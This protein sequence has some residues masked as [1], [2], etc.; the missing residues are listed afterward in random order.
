MKYKQSSFIKNKQNHFQQ[1]NDNDNNGS[2]GNSNNNNNNNN[3]NGNNGTR[4]YTNNNY[5]TNGNHEADHH[6]HYHNH[7][8]RQY[9]N[10]NDL[11]VFQDNQEQIIDKQQDLQITPNTNPT[12][13]LTPSR[14]DSYNRINSTSSST[15][16]SSTNNTTNIVKTPSSIFEFSNIINEQKQQQLKPS[17]P[18]IIC[19]KVKR[20]LH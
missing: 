4:N 2:N 14:K 13:R 16:S 10:N 3:N 19:S 18:I 12:N 11:S 9:D 1:N 7:Q 8:Q 5:K 15:S 6:H 17:K 20:H